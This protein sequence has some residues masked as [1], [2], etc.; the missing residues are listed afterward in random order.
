MLRALCVFSVLLAA[1]LSCGATA[2]ELRRE[3]V[4]SRSLGR[5]MRFVVYLPDGYKDSG[6]RY[7]VLYLLHGAGGDENTWAERGGVK[8]KADALIASGA[9]PPALIVMPG[10]YACWWIDGAK[11]KAETAFWTDLLP[12][13][14]SRYRIIE[15]KG[16]RLVA[17]Y[18]AGGYGAVR[19]ALRYPD[20]IAAAAAL[21]PAIYAATPPAKSAARAQP[22]FLG[23]NGKFSQAA[24]DAHNYPRLLGGYFA[25]ASRVPIYL[26]SGD[27][28]GLGIAFETRLLF[29]KLAERQPEIAQLR[30]VEGDHNWKVWSGALD[31]ALAYIFRFA[32]RPQAAT[33]TAKAP[34]PARASQR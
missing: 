4:D 11:D 9:M 32:D 33:L 19:F 25:Q 5:A 1:G 17:G 10:C 14:A 24:W 6:L 31:E 8:E 29:K 22:P 18:S 13:I 3:V 2:G 16:G 27:K 30:I 26:A 15:T 21:S 28:D 20:R 34:E 12:A 23:P 7:P